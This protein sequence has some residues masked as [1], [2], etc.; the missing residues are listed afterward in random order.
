MAATTDGRDGTGERAAERD[1]PRDRVTAPGHHPRVALPHTEAEGP[2]AEA[3][4]IAA[5]TAAD[6]RPHGEPGRPL[7]RRSPFMIGLIGSAGVAVTAGFV[8]IVLSAWSALLLIG[9]ALFLAIGL[10]PAVSGLVRRGVKRSLAVTGV[11][12]LLV[13]LVAGFFAAAIVPL[14]AQA[15]ALFGRAPAILQ[16]LQ[17]R[18]SLLGGLGARLQVQQRIGQL[19]SG[20]GSALVN[21]VLGAGVALFGA[22]TNALI[23]L[24]LTVYFLA[25]LPSIRVM[26]YRF[27]PHSRRPRAI[28]I[29]DEVL[30]KVGAYVLG[31]V[32]VSVITGLAT[33]IWLVIFH[34]PYPLALSVL[35]ALLDLV[36]VVGS[37]IA[38]IIVAIVALSVSWPI[39]LATVAFYVLYR[40]VEDYLL[41]PKIMG[42]AVNV[43]GTVTVVAVLVGGVLLGV[44]G[45]LVAI[46]VAA[47]VMLV[48]REAV[49]PR[50][51]RA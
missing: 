13:V 1:H 32:L 41:V 37:T 49:F 48:V 36:P 46:P 47:A 22:L 15:A 27:V 16:E 23:V 29:G 17:N 11:A 6:D 9:V 14:A 51:D 30:A 19:V 5:L 33:F 8:W 31:N 7:D 25:S 34:V 42:R 18:S 2:I 39:A 40:F 21:G 3:E 28:L 20:S 10:E 38:G 44:A 50:L 4:R 35:V 24:V 43:P 26:V 45:A 12:I